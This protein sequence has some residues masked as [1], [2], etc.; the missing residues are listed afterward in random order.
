MKKILFLML[1][2]VGASSAFAQTPEEKAALKAAQK[3]AKT[4]ASDGIKLRDEVLLQLTDMRGVAFRQ[5]ACNDLRHT[6]Y[7]QVDAVCVP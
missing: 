4:Q 2:L 3:L 1:M 5:M 6:A 7:R